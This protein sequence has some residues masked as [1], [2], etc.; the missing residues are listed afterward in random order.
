MALGNHCAAIDQVCLLARHDARFLKHVT[1]SE[2]VNAERGCK[3]GWGGGGLE[4]LMLVGLQGVIVTDEEEA[5]GSHQELKQLHQG[6]V[7]P[8][9]PH[10]YPSTKPLT[11]LLSVSTQTTASLKLY[12][13][14]LI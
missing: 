1:A 2:W 14:I 7:T 3:G 9:W 11:L 6:G 8:I 13:Q 12:R 10:L 4:Y 5:H